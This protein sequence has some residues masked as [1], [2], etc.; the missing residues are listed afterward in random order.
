MEHKEVREGEER[1]IYFFRDY[2]IVFVTVYNEQ[3]SKCR[4]ALREVLQQLQSATGCHAPRAAPTTG[5]RLPQQSN[6]AAARKLFA[7]DQNTC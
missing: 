5:M 1:S 4:N 7:Q 3:M 6:D 2:L